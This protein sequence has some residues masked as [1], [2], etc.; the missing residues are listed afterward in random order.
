M[1]RDNRSVGIEQMTSGLGGVVGDPD[2]DDVEERGRARGD[3][4]VPQGEGVEASG[5]DGQAHAATL[6][7]GHVAV[8]DAR[9]S[10]PS[11][12]TPLPAGT[13]ISRNVKEALLYFLCVHTRDSQ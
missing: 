10:S 13:R 2:D 7:A 5:V 11:V 6:M 9:R 1:A 4:D 8:R 12:L 3:V